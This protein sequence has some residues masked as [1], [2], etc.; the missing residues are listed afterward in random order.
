M[1]NVVTSPY[2]ISESFRDILFE[3]KHFERRALRRA[4]RI[5][6]GRR[7][8]KASRRTPPAKCISRDCRLSPSA[9]LDALD[10]Y[11]RNLMKTRDPNPVI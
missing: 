1:V 11:Y 7:L 5:S 3:V 6:G 2:N 8:W 9:V 10:V 4:G